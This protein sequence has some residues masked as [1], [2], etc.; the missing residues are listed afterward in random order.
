MRAAIIDRLQVCGPIDLC[1]QLASSKRCICC[2]SIRT[3]QGKGQ[4]I[5]ACTQAVD[6]STL[7][8]LRGA[9]AKGYAFDRRYGQDVLSDNIYDDCIAQLVESVFKVS[10]M[11]ACVRTRH[12]CS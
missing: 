6:K 2:F 11:Y 8:Q 5:G 1:E 9:G 3:H 7:L 4:A 10:S 12:A